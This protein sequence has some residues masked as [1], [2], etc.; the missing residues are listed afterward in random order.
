MGDLAVARPV[1]QSE[2]ILALD[3]LRGFAIFGVLVAYCLWSLGMAP[4]ESWSPLDKALGE[5]LGFAVDGKF[6]T[7][8]SFL[9]GLGFSIQL[10][11]APSDASAV[12]LYSRRLAV[13]AGIGLAHALLLRNG[14]ILVPYALT[15]FLLIPF[16]RSSDRTLAAVAA[17]A[18]LIAA[19]A[20]VIWEASG[21]P[22]PQRPQLEDAPYLVENAAWVGFWYK[23]AIFTWPINLTMFLL[24]LLAGRHGLVTRLQQRPRTLAAIA[25]AGL[26]LGAFFYAALKL[27]QSMQS[28]LSPAASSLL[29]TFHCWGL[30]SA[31][32]A[33]LLLI[34]RTATGASGLKALAAVGRLALTNYL[35][36]ATL[37]VP[38]CLLFGWFDRFTPTSGLALALALFL[39]VQLP[40][41]ILWL[42]HF[43]FG[44]AEWLWRSLTYRGS[45]RLKAGQNDPATL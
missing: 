8:L 16:R 45:T 22:V 12:S 27:S 17:V 5:I 4:E 23:T 10:R 39:I 40:F 7:I 15:G 29:F 34:L 14:D 35:S 36:Q 38:L 28:P 21:L 20:H 32:A 37:I 25:A 13:L 24:G 30:S 18:L 31:Y 3:V 41:S 42:R 2:R 19:L 43:Q 11:R 33:A 44:P 9:F 1:A 6:Y 26:A